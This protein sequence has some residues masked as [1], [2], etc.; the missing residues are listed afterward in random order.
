[1]LAATAERMLDLDRAVIDG[2]GTP[3]DLDLAGVARLLAATVVHLGGADLDRYLV[4]MELVLESRRRGLFAAERSDARRAF[5]VL[6]GDL[7]AGAGI[8]APLDH[9]GPVLALVDGLVLDRVLF[10]GVG[11]DGAAV[12]Q[13]IERF[14]RSIEG[15]P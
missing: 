12:E 13:V 1:M 3:P 5:L 11:V 4:R 2:R 7:L 10:G 8:A 14:L 9:A 15:A 6:V